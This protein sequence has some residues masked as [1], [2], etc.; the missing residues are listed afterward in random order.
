[1]LK[2]KWT[3]LSPTWEGMPF[4]AHAA[5]MYMYGT[6]HVDVHVLPPFKPNDYLFETH[7]EQG[8]EKWEVYAWAV[9]DVMA[10]FGSFNKATQTNSEKIM[11]KNFMVGKT[12]K[13]EYEGKTWTAPSM[14]TKLPEK[15]RSD[16]SSEKRKSD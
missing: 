2:Y 13:L 12:D 8:K 6:F 1:V 14:H 9:R 15:A 10:R 11:Y 3:Y 5:L 7:K 4:I 16:K